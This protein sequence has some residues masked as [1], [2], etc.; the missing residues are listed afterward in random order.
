MKLIQKGDGG[1]RMEEAQTEPEVV[2]TPAADDEPEE[3]IEEV[4]EEIQLPVPSISS[5]LS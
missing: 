3:E 1:I 2:E 4:E 5:W